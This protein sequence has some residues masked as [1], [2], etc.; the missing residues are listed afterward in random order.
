MGFF[1]SVSRWWRVRTSKIEALIDADVEA[2]LTDPYVMRVYYKDI[3]AARRVRL[4]KFRDAVGRH[5]AIQIQTGRAL[6]EAK[7]AVEKTDRLSKGYLAQAMARK[8]Q[9]EAEGKT[10][11]EIR[12]DVAFMQSKSGFDAQKANLAD[13]T[14]EVSR[15]ETQLK[16]DTV[17]ANKLEIQLTGE[18]RRIDDLER[19]ATTNEAR[20]AA[21]KARKDAADLLTGMSTDSTVNDE[22]MLDKAVDRLEATAE[23]TERL[24]GTDSVLQDAQAL[25]ALESRESSDEF[26]N[27]VGLATKADGG[28]K[29]APVA[30]AASKLPE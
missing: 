11:D 3:L 30:E 26:D 4:V 28:S 1:E 21:A 27:L 25:A 5:A 8:A 29:V 10:A 19:K 23:V 2:D 7:D 9:L 20:A 18:K 14:A 12:L 16:L 15:L 22:A 17:T 6:K 13:K 24:A